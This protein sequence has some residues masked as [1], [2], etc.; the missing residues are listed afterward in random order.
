MPMDLSLR[1][2]RYLVA[3]ADQGSVTAAARRLHVSQP[4]ISEALAARGAELG[5]PLFLRHHAKGVTP[6][7]AGARVVAEARQLLAHAG[8]F[9]RAARALGGHPAGEIT[10]GCFLTVAPRFLPRLLAAFAA[11]HPAISV[12]L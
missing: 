8:D 11:R 1:A 4:S 9:A 6:T 2:L 5:L 7:P 10:L 3:V 12:R